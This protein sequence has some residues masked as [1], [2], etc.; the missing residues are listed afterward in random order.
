MAGLVPAIRVFLLLAHPPSVIAGLDPAIHAMT[1][2]RAP[3][4]DFTLCPLQP[5][6]FF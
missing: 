3:S 1:L 6:Q 2:P 4:G 5:R